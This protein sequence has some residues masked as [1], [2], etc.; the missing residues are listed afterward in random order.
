MYFVEYFNIA[1]YIMYCYITVYAF[2]N[3]KMAH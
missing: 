2:V 3:G 1:C